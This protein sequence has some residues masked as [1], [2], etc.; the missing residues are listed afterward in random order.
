MNMIHANLKYDSKQGQSKP[1][2]LRL[3]GFQ[4][5]GSQ[6]FA[7][8]LF[9]L[10]LLVTINRV[11]AAD[12]SV[13]RPN[14]LVLFVDDLGR[15]DLG[16]YGS[17]FYETP[18]IDRLARSG[19]QFAQF[20]SA[21]PVCSPTRAALMTGKVPQRVGITQWIPQPSNVHL[22]HAETTLAEAFQSAGYR[23]G[24][25]GKWHLGEA[26]HQQ[27]LNH[28]FD[29]QRGV[30]RA[31]APG[32][33]FFP[34]RRK[35]NQQKKNYWDVPDFEDG[36][37]GDYLTDHL[38]DAAIEFISEGG[39]SPFFLCLAH[40]AV[41]TPI[42][43]P[44]ALVRRFEQKR[45]TVY[46]DTKAEVIPEKN[47]AGS[48]PRQDNPAYAAM[49]S[50]LDDNVG[51][52]LKCLEDRQLLENTVVVLT[53]DNGGLSTLKNGRIGPTSCLPMRAGKGWNYEGGIGIPTLVSWPGH[54]PA[55]KEINDPAITMDLYPTLLDLV[56]LDL[57]PQQHLD[58]VSLAPLLRGQDSPSTRERFL[59]WHYPHNHGSGHSPSSALRRGDYKLLLRRGQEAPELYHLGND[60]GEQS[61]LSQQQ[62]VLAAELSGLLETWLEE[63]CQEREIEK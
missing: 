32:S 26:D 50:N 47:N 58:G 62:P 52:L 53:S 19:A 1:G 41:H 36:Q 28:G 27:P 25:I 40:Y 16:C 14:V 37:Q 15:H 18:H 12:D 31:G 45:Q 48:R 13:A 7:V 51:R 30:N 35:S 5:S 56:G 63:T 2:L 3:S 33:Y 49:V 59:A 8:C 43:S 61:N 20:Y 34:Y 42:Q 39:Q 6:R 4:R 9:V 60:P 17:E 57:K 38:T 24:Y 22:P 23:T 54:V 46:G 44:P 29:W 21:H 11:G 10:L 55:G